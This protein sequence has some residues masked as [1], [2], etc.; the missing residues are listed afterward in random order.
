MTPFG[1]KKIPDIRK[2][3]VKK[4]DEETILK[5]KQDM[6]LAEAKVQD[7]QRA[8]DLLKG[9]NANEIQAAQARVNAAQATLKLSARDRTVRRHDY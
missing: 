3:K 6:D 7:A 2:V 8:Y 1:L 9:G 4:A 5:A